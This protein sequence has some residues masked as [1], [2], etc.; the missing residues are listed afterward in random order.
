M[1]GIPDIFL[2]PPDNESC[3]LNSRHRVTRRFFA[4]ASM[5]WW[6]INANRDV[7]AQP[8]TAISSAPTNHPHTHHN[9]LISG[10]QI[11]DYLLFFCYHCFPDRDCTLYSVQHL[12]QLAMTSSPPIGHLLAVCL[13][14][15][16]VCAGD[17]EGGGGVPLFRHTF[18][19]TPQPPLCFQLSSSALSPYIS[20]FPFPLP[21]QKKN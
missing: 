7:G 18:T 15:V 19:T 4:F 11:I 21:H 5:T 13:V 2:L 16:C 3:F 14:C 20:H 8:S 9:N 1:S 6:H 12:P 17:W 10:R